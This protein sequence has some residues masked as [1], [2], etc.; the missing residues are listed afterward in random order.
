MAVGT[1]SAARSVEL[2]LSKHQEIFKNMRH[3]VCGSSDPAIKNGKPAPD[4]FLEVA[5]RFQEKP[6][7]SQV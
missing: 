5:N 3:I 4:I 7:P 6:K 2:K 1:S